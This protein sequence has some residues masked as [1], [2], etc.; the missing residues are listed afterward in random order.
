MIIRLNSFFFFPLNLDTLYTRYLW[1]RKIGGW[2]GYSVSN[3]LYSLFLRVIS[4][5]A[6]LID[7]LLQLSGK[8]ISSHVT[9][10]IRFEIK[11]RDITRGRKISIMR[12]FFPCSAES[13]MRC[14][15]LSIFFLLRNFSS[16]FPYHYFS[17]SDVFTWLSFFPRAFV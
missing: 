16:L 11:S 15:A 3:W 2:N 1:M 8:L 5:N 14:Y 13:R 17:S 9:R 12:K 7:I 6:S 10:V 4:T